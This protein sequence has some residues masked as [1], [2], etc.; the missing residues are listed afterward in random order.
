MRGGF[1]FNHNQQVN[2]FYFEWLIFFS[3]MKTVWKQKVIVVVLAR[4]Q[5]L[6]L[7]K[8]NTI[9][10]CILFTSKTGVFFNWKA[11][12]FGSKEAVCETRAS[13]TLSLTNIDLSHCPKLT[14]LYANNFVGHKAFLMSYQWYR[15]INKPL[16]LALLSESLQNLSIYGNNFGI[17]LLSVVKLHV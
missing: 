17:F 13:L 11:N 14:L 15:L 7:A 8:V 16:W 12:C 2:M 3:T 4:H 10:N 6:S 1:Y 9:Y 5:L